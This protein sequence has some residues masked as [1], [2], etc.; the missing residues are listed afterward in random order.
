MKG[1]I[2]VMDSNKQM[3]ELLFGSITKTPED[4]E[5]LYPERNLNEG[6]V[7]TRFAPSPTG[8]I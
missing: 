7:V 3:A 6:A 2:K 5:E 8:F 4:Y 1:I